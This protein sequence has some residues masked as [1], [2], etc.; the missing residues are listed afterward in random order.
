HARASRS[1]RGSREGMM[2]ER[3]ECTDECGIKADRGDAIIG[4]HPRRLGEIP[5]VEIK[6]HERFRMLRYEGDR[7]H[8][9][10][11]PLPAGLLDLLVCRWFD[12]P[13]R[14]NATLIADTPVEPRP[15]K[16]FDDCRRG[17]LDLA[18]IR[19]TRAHDLHWQAMRGEQ[20][21]RALHRGRGGIECRSD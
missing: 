8:D 4:G 3:R 20:Q 13:Q 5:V 12:P 9:E 10:R 19:I 2:H 18:W 15:R 17:L 16:R 14:S 11:Y 21:T 1:G 6:F 7:R